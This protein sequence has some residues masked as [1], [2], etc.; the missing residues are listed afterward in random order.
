MVKNILWKRMVLGY[1]VITLL[2]LSMSFY[3]IFRLK[4]LNQA[5]TSILS[6]D[7]PSIEN[8]EKLL[9]ILLEQVSSEKKYTITRDPAFLDIFAAKKSEFIHRLDLVNK[10]I[11][12]RV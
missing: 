7:I 3:L 5:S 9:K 1:V 11:Q 2:M 6:K 8:E 4:H 12:I 10:L